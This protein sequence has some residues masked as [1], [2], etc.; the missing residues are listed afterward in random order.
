MAIATTE[1]RVAYDGTG[2]QVDFPVDFVYFDKTHLYVYVDGVLKALTTDYTVSPAA[3]TTNGTVGGTVTFLTAPANGAQV[4]IVRV[5][6][7]VQE[8]DYVENAK[9]LADT[10]ERALDLLTM[11]AQQ[12]DESLSRCVKL[13]LTSVNES[14]EFPDL[15]VA[16]AGKFIR[17]KGDGSGLEAVDG[18]SGG[19]QSLLTTKGD[20][21]GYS[22]AAGRV[23]VGANESF[24][25]ADSTQSF[26]WKWT[27]FSTKL[28]AKLVAALLGILTTKG[29]LLAS[30]GSTVQRKAVGADGTA[31][32]ASSA[33]SD[34]MAWVR[35]CTPVNLLTNTQWKIRTALNV[36]TKYGS[37]GG[38]TLPPLACTGYTVGA[39]NVVFSCSDTSELKLGDIVLITSADPSVMATGMEV[40]GI[41][42]N[43]AFECDLPLGKIAANS[44]ACSAQIVMRGDLAG[45]TG[46]GPDAW[47]KSTAMYLFID[48][49]AVNRKVGSKYQVGLVQTAAAQQFWYPIEGNKVTSY[50]GK[51]VVFGCWVN[52]KVRSGSGTYRLFINDGVNATTYSPAVSSTGYVWTEITHA[53]ADT[54]A[55]VSFGIECNGSTS[56][57]FYVSQPMMSFG[58]VLG[59]G[60]YQ[61]EP[62][63]TM[64]TPRVKFTPL[65]WENAVVSTPAAATNGYAYGYPFYLKA[66]TLEAVA[67]EVVAAF[68]E[69][70]GVNATAGHALAFMQTVFAPQLDGPIIHTQTGGQKASTS[71][72]WWFQ[73]NGQAF[74]YTIHGSDTYS[75]V[76]FD[77]SGYILN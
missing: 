12:L 74:I 68:T 41:T 32:I 34:G 66:E 56:D 55:G 21:L 28:G 47:K 29:D 5:V 8:T 2:S 52:Y 70:E 51:T 36:H 33:Q 37:A 7:Y 58:S 62:S 75:N 65:H 45:V 25:E 63:G 13:P 10:H 46:D 44:E 60:N 67:N 14:S 18:S 30:T 1:N 9:F 77:M 53:I 23:A 27:N 35:P 3:D 11:Q 15:T 40:K 61:P 17:I 71:S 24:I 39:N 69:L 50:Q 42:P 73:D 43:V 76:S 20:L 31:L 4:L 38:G 54:T 16:N 26:G 64:F 19:D 59:Q 48:D 57:V 49:H 22:S 6:P 72:W